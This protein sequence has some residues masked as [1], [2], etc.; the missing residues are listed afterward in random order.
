M[1]DSCSGMVPENEFD[2][3]SKM[4]SWFKVL[5]CSGIVPERL[6]KGA[7]RVT[8]AVSEDRAGGS[9]PE[10]LLFPSFKFW[11]RTRVLNCCGMGPVSWFEVTLSAVRFTSSDIHS[12]RL[13]A[14]IL[15]RKSRVIKPV[16]WQICVGMGPDNP[17][18]TKARLDNSFRVKISGSKSS[19]GMLYTDNDITLALEL[20]R[21]PAIEHAVF[22]EATSQLASWAKE[23]HDSYSAFMMRVSVSFCV[24]VQTRVGIQRLLQALT[25]TNKAQTGSHLLESY[26]VTGGSMYQTHTGANTVVAE[27]DTLKPG[28]LSVILCGFELRLDWLVCC[29]CFDWHLQRKFKTTR[30]NHVYVGT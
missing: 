14:S 24:A 30:D 8:R 29:K 16:S 4:L 23:P 15:F 6:F 26:N 19:V 18:L 25:V 20:Q 3:R 11:S 1:F 13:Y 5:N 22:P 7:E 27:R 12:G 10:N 21:I 9:E 17:A 28:W 2:P